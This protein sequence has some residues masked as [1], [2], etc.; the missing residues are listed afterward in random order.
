MIQLTLS[1]LETSALIRAAGRIPELEYLFKHGLVQE[2]TYESLLKHDRKRLHRFVAETLERRYPEQMDELAPR[3]AAHWD[4]AGEAKRAF[5][6]YLRAGS[7]AARVYANAEALVEY[8]RARALS[9]GLELTSAQ[10]LDLYSSRGRVLELRGEYDPALASYAEL[11]E[12][13]RGRGDGA[14]ELQA[15]IR[16]VTVMGTPTRQQN[17]AEAERLAQLAL[18]MA[19]GLKDRRAEAQLLWTLSFIAQY[20]GRPWD[21]VRYGEASLEIARALDMREQ[22][23]YTLNDLARAYMFND[24]IPQGQRALA[25]VMDLWREQGNLPML[26]DT[27]NSAG[28]YA[29]ATGNYS[30]GIERAR[31]GG[32]ISHEIGNLWGE[33]FSA[34]AVG[35]LSLLL[36]RTADAAAALDLAIR[37]GAQ[38]DYLDAQLTGYTFLAYLYVTMGAPGQA[39]DFLERVLPQ[40]P[41]QGDWI[42]GAY[43]VLA[44]AKAAVGDFTAAESVLERARPLIPEGFES[45][46]PLVVAMAELEVAQRAGRLSQLPSLAVELNRR[47]ME[48]KV[49]PFVVLVLYYRASALRQQRDIEGAYALLKEARA[50]GEAHQTAIFLWRVLAAL[51]EVEVARGNANAAR[52]IRQRA[53]ET[54][55]IIADHAPADLRRTFLAQR[56]VQELECARPVD[57]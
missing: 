6:Y 16:R 41:E 36:G 21:G 14:L 15:I 26:T 4:E 22:I 18:G 25:D 52:D 38:A 53:C 24:Q 9:A 46:T 50:L 31:E 42:G 12:M 49:N 17:S 32:R 54:V 20:A 51:A 10:L 3:L 11:E 55:Q 7:N 40:F 56:A 57:L 34:E 30:E 8:N 43:G 23:A 27:L 2:T 47:S 13:A 33:S 44:W 39:I 48:A 5:D 28:F 29:L 19:R 35:I 1:L 45:P 37:I